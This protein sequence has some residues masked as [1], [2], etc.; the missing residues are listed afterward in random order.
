MQSRLASVS[1]DGLSLRMAEV[2]SL[3]QARYVLV[4]ATLC[5][6]PTHTRAEPHLSSNH[7]PR[8]FLVSTSSTGDSSLAAEQEGSS[9]KRAF[10]QQST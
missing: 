8:D 2:R 7:S 5:A 6:L 4:R 3:P 9:R 10:A 1:P